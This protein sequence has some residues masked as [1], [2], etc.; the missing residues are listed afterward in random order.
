MESR[1]RVTHP[2]SNPSALKASQRDVNAYINFFRDVDEEA[3]LGLD[4]AIMTEYKIT[5]ADIYL[6]SIS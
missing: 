4:T 2:P 5:I 1:I 3:E 6:N